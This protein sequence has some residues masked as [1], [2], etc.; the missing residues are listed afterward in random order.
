MIVEDEEMDR[1]LERTN[2]AVI[3]V[4]GAAAHQLDEAEEYGAFAG[5]IKPVEP[6]ALMETLQEAVNNLAKRRD[7]WGNAQ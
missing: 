3:A 1:L 4:S 5:L 7:I 6:E 2:A